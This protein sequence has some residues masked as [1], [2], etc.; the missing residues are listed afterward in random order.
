MTSQGH[1]IT[2]LQRQLERRTSSA[3]IRAAAAEMPAPLP[4]DVALDVCLA[5]LELE[6]DSYPLLASRWG[7]R[8]AIEKKLTLTDAQ[9]TLAALAALPGPGA[10]AG[11]E[12]LIEIAD[13]YRLHR[14]DRLLPAWL[15]RRGLDTG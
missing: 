8:L 7:S 13:R 9:L 6:P 14:V 2:R 12:A 1:A 10:K 11:A 15:E 5:L 3:L 4:L